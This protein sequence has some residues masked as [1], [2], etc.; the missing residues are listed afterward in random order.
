MEK[1][2]V[3]GIGLVT[4]LGLGR[5]KT[6]AELLNSRSAVKPV[7][8][9]ERNL[10]AQVENLNVLPQ[11]RLLSLGFLAAAEALYE[12]RDKYYKTDSSRIGCTV[13][14]SKPN[15]LLRKDQ[16]FTEAFLTSYLNDQLR[17]IFRFEGPMLNVNA[18]C[19]SGAFSVIIASQWIEQGLCDVVLC[20]GVESSFHPLYVAGF[21]NLGVLAKTRPAPFD[22]KREG[23][24]LGE[25]A[26]ILVLEKKASAVLRGAKIYGEISSCSMTCD[27]A[28]T[29]AFDATGTSVARALEQCVKKAGI[30]TPDYINAH[31]TGTRLNDLMETRA[32]KKVFGRAAKKISIS[33]TKAATGHMLGA[34][35]S[36]ELGFCLLALRDNVI[37]PTLNL[38]HPDPE[39]DLDYTPNVAKY[40]NLNSAV[41]LSFGFGG[42]ISA[43]CVKRN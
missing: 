5:E 25:G 2:V 19:A 43:I 29:I 20:G 35:G 14:V 28:N 13:S 21:K 36:S 38:D 7:Y 9:N 1:A 40:K 22:R 24:A 11:T 4:P 18:A 17:R 30:D 10:F 34:S 12:S 23:F 15:L 41:S 6:W 27:A 32:I 26:G 42:Q 31:G 39:C 8:S 16:L 37:P 3:T 33:S